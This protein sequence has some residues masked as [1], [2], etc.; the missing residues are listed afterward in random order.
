MT[1]F[2]ASFNV[3]LAKPEELAEPSSDIQ[4]KPDGLGGYVLQVNS[5]SDYFKGIFGEQREFHKHERQQITLFAI[6]AFL[7]RNPMARRRYLPEAED[8]SGV[9]VAIARLAEVTVERGEL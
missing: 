5:G 1:N 4:T 9:T 6:G 2:F 3:V 7:R 8:A